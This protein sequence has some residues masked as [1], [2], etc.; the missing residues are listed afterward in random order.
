METENQNS[1]RIWN[2][3]QCYLKDAE[4]RLMGDMENILAK[5]CSFGVKLVRGAYLTH[6]TELSQRTGRPFE[7]FD[8]KSETDACYDRYRSQNP[9]I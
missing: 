1:A 9:L 8:T 4:A 2:T 7:I 5:G 6:E 3:Y